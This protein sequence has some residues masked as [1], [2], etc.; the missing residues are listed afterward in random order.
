MQ[1]PFSP[2]PLDGL[3]QTLQPRGAFYFHSE[4]RGPW[5]LAL[6][7]GPASFHIV[8]DGACAVEAD[9]D[10]V[11][12]E[13]G[14][15]AVLPHGR[16]YTLTDRPGRLTL[17]IDAMLAR[18]GARGG[19]H[20]QKDGDGP[21]TTLV[22]GGVAFDDAFPHPLVETLPSLIVIRGAT[23]ETVPWLSHTLGFLACEAQSE[24]P[25]AETVMGHLASVLF[26][27][28]IRAHLTTD[29]TGDGGWL[30]ALRDPHLGPAITAFQAAPAEPWTVARLADEA[31]L[32]RS[33]FSARFRTVV[34]EPPMQYATRWRMYRAAQLLRTERL[35][36]AD[37]A[38]RVGYESEA[39]F[40]RA[41]KRW[42]DRTPGAFRRAHAPRLHEAA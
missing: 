21:L 16:P 17:P 7:A 39:A 9:G 42:T 5:G 41:F 26:I 4:L 40:N 18:Y 23:C 3:L 11:N 22:C 34:G 6:P 32:S 12:L 10:I 19:I 2:D 31:G 27:Q 24:R 14:D 33:A 36:L 15:V 35:T 8:L 28:A 37:V 1:P 25:G 30:R 20:L 38:A 29:D 13:A